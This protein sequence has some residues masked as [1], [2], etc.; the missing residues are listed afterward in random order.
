M[1]QAPFHILFSGGVTGGH[2]FPGLAVAERL[3]ALRPEAKITFAGAG[4][5]LDRQA[6]FEAGFDYLG[7]PC[8]ATPR[9]L[10][11]VPRFLTTN[12]KGFRKAARFLRENRID[13]VVGLGGYA[14]VPAARAAAHAGIP[15]VLLEQNLVPGR[16]TRWLAR[17][18]KLVLLSFSETRT[19]LHTQG[20]T[21][22][23]GNPVREAFRSTTPAAKSQTKKPRL[24]VLGGSQGARELNE[25]VPRALYR[26]RAT[27][28]SWEILHQSG[29][30]SHADAAS[31]Y[32]KFGLPA[33]VVPFVHD[34]AALMKSAD[35]VIARAGGTTLA[36]LAVTGTPAVLCPLHTA[37]DDHQRRNAEYF[38]AQGAAKLVDAHTVGCRLD[39]HLGDEIEPLLTCAQERAALSAGMTRLARPDAAE[40]AAQ[41]IL[42]LAGADVFAAPAPLLSGGAAV[43]IGG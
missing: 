26:C 11:E 24:L 2:L 23:V 38:A 15:L 7:V 36:E 28:S 40:R 16:A 41:R 5:S 8:H 4:R 6:V 33:R 25:Q 42:E 10:V 35:L 22:V 31:L 13:A 18:A 32:R 21:L 9:R 1:I 29:S 12:R 27:L 14:S 3:V 37:A 34:M 17:S 30:P 43:E 19:Q 39:V 20:K